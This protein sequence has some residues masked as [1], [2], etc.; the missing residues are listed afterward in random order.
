VGESSEDLLP[1]DAVV[2]EVDRLG[3]AAACLGWG[4]L[5]EGTVRPVLLGCKRRMAI[6]S[7]VFA[8]QDASVVGLLVQHVWCTLVLAARARAARGVDLGHELAVGCAGGG[9]VLIAFFELEPQV[10]DLLFKVR[11]LAV[12]RVDVGRGTES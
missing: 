9:E 1:S 10:G 6:K 11:D 4:E 8:G 3:R 5:A 12:E 7:S 2:G